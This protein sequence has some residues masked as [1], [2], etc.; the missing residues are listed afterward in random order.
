MS[1]KRVPLRRA[2]YSRAMPARRIV[3]AYA[4]CSVVGWI[5]ALA[6]VTKSPSPLY[7]A[8]GVVL[9]AAIILGLWLLWRPV[10]VVTVGLSVL[11]E[12]LDALHP[13]RRAVLLA[14][15]AVQ[16]VLLLLRP[17]RRELRSRPVTR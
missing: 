7:M 9:N 4:S 13:V 16:L 12:L 17:L 14:I 15:G 3:L 8:P 6:S 11:G 2:V 5:L 10:W 1:P